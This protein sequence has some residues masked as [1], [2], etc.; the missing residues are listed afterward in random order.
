MTVALA[1]T[2]LNGIVALAGVWIV[3]AGGK[4]SATPTPTAT[5]RPAPPAKTA[6]PK[7]RAVGPAAPK[8]AKKATPP[9]A[10]ASPSP[11]PLPKPTGAASASEVFRPQAPGEA[12]ALTVLSGELRSRLV[13]LRAIFV[14]ITILAVALLGALWFKK[15]LDLA[16][17]RRADLVLMMTQIV[18]IS[19]GIIGGLG[20]A[21][22]VEPR[23][24]HA[25]LPVL[26]ATT[27]LWLALVPL[28]LLLPRLQKFEFGGAS[29]SLTTETGPKVVIDVASLLENWIGALNLLLEWLPT[30]TNPAETI[31]AFLRDRSDEAIR[32]M[33]PP[34]ERLRL[35][36]WNYVD[37]VSG[38]KFL[39][40]NQITD[41]A[42]KNAI[43]RDGE[44]CLG[45]AYREQ[46]VWN[47][48]DPRDLACWKKIPGGSSDYNGLLLVPIT[49]ADRKVGMLSIDRESAEEFDEA[50]VQVARALAYLAANALGSPI[51]IAALERAE[52]TAAAAAVPPPT[53]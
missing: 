26:D 15:P 34:R 9:K 40:S 43:F 5:V 44:G 28:G 33:S 16:R 27:V 13:I 7:P 22:T 46:R 49:W 31:R 39:Q 38:L 11:S 23:A 41:D 6:S 36:I 50:S 2:A 30:D 14:E 10:T 47:E 24:D 18:T 20:R 3:T 42:T 29:F 4:P 32:Q 21:L 12:F 48:K 45:M 52:S 17:A 25:F 51:S 37:E 8:G 35:A 53:P 19:A 1:A